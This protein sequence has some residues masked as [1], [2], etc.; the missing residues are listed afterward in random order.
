V[1]NRGDSVARIGMRGARGPA[2]VLDHSIGSKGSPGTLRDPAQSLFDTVDHGH[3][4][5]FL[6][7]RVRDGM[8]LRLIGKWLNAGV[9]EE[10]H[11][12][13][14]DSGTQQGGVFTPPTQLT[15]M[16]FGGAGATSICVSLVRGS[17][18]AACCKGRH[19][20]NYRCSVITG[21]PAQP[22]AG[23]EP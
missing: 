8:L 17:G 20:V 1:T 2:G 23:S 13:R 14:P 16:I 21:M 10:G 12:W 11:E 22:T 7:K 5:T 19:T 3:L 9:M 4:R 6:H 18:F 15:K